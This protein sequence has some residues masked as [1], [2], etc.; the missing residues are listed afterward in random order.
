MEGGYRYVS[1]AGKKIAQH[2]LIVEE[3]EGRPLRSD[4][5]VHHVDHDR[6]NNAPENL[7]ILSRSEHQRLH[8]VGIRNA[9]WSP[10]EI[11]RAAALREA[12]MTL[13]EISLAIGRPFSSVSRR[14]CKSRNGRLR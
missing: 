2:R 7:V 6:L 5:L 8:T 14:L 3:R 9:R 4:E 10:E 1:R 12:G 13:Q 11:Q